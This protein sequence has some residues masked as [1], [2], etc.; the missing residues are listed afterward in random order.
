MKY[1]LIQVLILNY[2]GENI[3]E[4]CLESVVNKTKYPHFKVAVIDNGSTDSSV[5]IIKKFKKAEIINLPYNYG[6]SGGFNQGISQKLTNIAAD[7][8]ALLNNDIIITDKDWL[9]KLVK[10]MI[11]KDKIGITSGPLITPS[12]L[13]QAGGNMKLNGLTM[14]YIEP[15]QS[16][17]DCYLEFTHGGAFLIRREVLQ[18]TS[19]FDEKFNPISN[20][21]TDFS[22][23]T[24]RL[25]YGI[26]FVHD[27]ELF[28]KHGQTIK[29]FDNFHAYYVMKRNMIRFRLLHYPLGWL[30]L[31]LFL[32]YKVILS[33]IFERKGII[34]SIRSKFHKYLKYYFLAVIVSILNIG[35][36][37]NRRT[38]IRLK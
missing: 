33:T 25:G 4:E 38:V 11:Q 13:R 16:K 8:F 24:R 29:R 3:I 23:R 31:S 14:S 18:R 19:G 15:N 20:E 26:Y 10:P 36:I 5:T 7:Y 9:T 27:V 2:N 37:M 35:E 22:V 30:F 17:K 28:H 12:G 32:E 34:I 1:P 6:F 21:E